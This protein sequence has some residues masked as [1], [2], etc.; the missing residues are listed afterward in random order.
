[1]K[2]IS[3]LSAAALSVTALSA[4]ADQI[5]LTSPLAGASL[6]AGDVDMSVYWTDVETGYEVVATYLEADAVTP[7]QMT[8]VLVDGD[9]V[10]FSLPGRLDHSYK[11]ARTGAAVTV[12]TLDNTA[13]FASN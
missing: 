4:H 10:T 7:A 12:K 13:L 2:T 6:H 9:A 11:F 3:L 5:T 8:L 1:M